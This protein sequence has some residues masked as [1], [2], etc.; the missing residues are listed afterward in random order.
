VC[1]N[2]TSEHSLSTTALSPTPPS[3]ALLN[4]RFNCS[5]FANTTMRNN[6][7][8]VTADVC[9]LTQQYRLDPKDSTK[10]SF[11]V[12]TAQSPQPAFNFSFG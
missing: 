9:F 10:F 11:R 2:T 3:R 7:G 5:S 1:T 6:V 8:S 12:L 4:P